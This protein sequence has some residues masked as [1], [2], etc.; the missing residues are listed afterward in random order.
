MTPSQLRR[1]RA[2]V[3][4]S[5]LVRDAVRVSL[6]AYLDASTEAVDDLVGRLDV[7]PDDDI[8]SVVY[9]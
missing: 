4:R 6:S 9:G 7:N 5:A 1:A 3:S 2:G 8:D